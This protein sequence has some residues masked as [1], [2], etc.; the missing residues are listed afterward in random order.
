MVAIKR[1]QDN[2]IFEILGL[3]KLWA[4]KSQ[5]TIPVNHIKTAYMNNQKISEHI[6]RTYPNSSVSGVIASGSFKVEEGTI[7]CDV[8]DKSRSIVVELEDEEYNK[9]VI[10]VKNPIE[11]IKML[12]NNKFI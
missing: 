11:T 8:V 4:M 9:L 3:R 2:Y 7:F 5:L 1:E 10:E 12:T 6:E